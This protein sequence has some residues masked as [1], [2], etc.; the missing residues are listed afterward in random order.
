[1]WVYNLGLWVLRFD[2]IVAFG[3]KS[4]LGCFEWLMLVC[5]Y[6]LPPGFPMGICLDSC[7]VVICL[8]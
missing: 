5:W 8:D 4:C 3:F 2:L 7:F 1:M 6:C